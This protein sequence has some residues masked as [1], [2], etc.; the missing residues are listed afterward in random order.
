MLCILHQIHIFFNS[1]LGSSQPSPHASNHIRI[2]FSRCI[3]IK[4]SCHWPSRLWLLLF[5]HYPGYL[6]KK[7]TSIIR[8]GDRLCLIGFST[9][10]PTMVLKSGK[11][12][13]L[14]SEQS[15]DRLNNLSC[16]YISE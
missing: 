5:S 7:L 2:K 12:H 14:T 8:R 15:A 10:P 9:L 1:R 11:P 13:A 6:K 3:L 4:H 16:I